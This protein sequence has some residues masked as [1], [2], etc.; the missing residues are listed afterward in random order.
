MGKLALFD[1]GFLQACRSFRVVG[2]AAARL[3]SRCL[4]AYCSRH[5]RQGGAAATST[6]TT[7]PRQ[8]SVSLAEREGY[9][10]RPFAASKELP[11]TQRTLTALYDTR[12]AAETARDGLVALGVPSDQIAVRGTEEGAASATTGEEDRGFWASLSD[13]FMPDEDRSTYTEGVRRGGYLLTTHVPEG[14]E[15]QALEVLERSDPVDLDQRAESWRQEG[16]TGSQ[17]GAA[18]STTGGATGAAAVAGAVPSGT[19][20]RAEGPGVAEAGAVS[21]AGEERR[22]DLGTEGLGATTASTTNAAGEEVIQA[23]EEQLR[24]GKRE[25]GRG[26]VRVRSY[27][28][29]RPVEQQVELQQERVTVERRP[30]DRELAP[31]EVAFQ[32]RTIEA[33]ERGEEAVVSKTARV[34]EEIGLRKDV[35]RET[36]TVR[37]TV[38]KQEIE[39]EDERAGSSSSARTERVATPRDSTDD[40]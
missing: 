12:G 36:E 16:W 39:V 1:H 27:V 25:V 38:R 7:P 8:G 18:A 3:E 31:G 5:L 40:R 34:T 6:G 14:M 9:G 13:L 37:D 29:E 15:D 4:Q 22:S 2:G 28:T 30:V 33:V 32:E 21:A 26:G 10:L 20:Y 19:A 23:A 35:E 24:V 17:A 11:M